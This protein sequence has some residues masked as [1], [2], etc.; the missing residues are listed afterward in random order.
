MFLE[1]T[2]AMKRFNQNIDMNRC[3]I[4]G[5]RNGEGYVIER[6]HVFYGYSSKSRTK[7]TFYGFVIPLIAQIHPN[8][9]MAD[10]KVCQRMTG[11]SLKEVDLELKRQCQAFY[12]MPEENGGMGRSREQFMAD[13]YKNFL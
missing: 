7:S 8:G 1:S 9:S 10:E 3:Y 11:M 6:H 12:E 4:T 13:F 2:R 5:I